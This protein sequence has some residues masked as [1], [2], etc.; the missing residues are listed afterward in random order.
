VADVTEHEI[1]YTDAIE[2]P[3][4]RLR[5]VIDTENG[6][7]TRFVVQLE[8]HHDGKWETVLFTSTTIQR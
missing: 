7:P 6:I 5:V 3:H 1:R 4:A 8:Y 2:Y